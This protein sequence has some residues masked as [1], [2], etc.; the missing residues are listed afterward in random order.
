MADSD[1]SQ[2]LTQEE[3]TALQSWSTVG[4]PSAT[5]TTPYVPD[6]E[7]KS[8]FQPI[9]SPRT[10]AVD[11]HFNL[12]AYEKFTLGHHAREME[13]KW[14]IYCEDN[15]VHFHRSW[16]GN[17]LF[18]FT[19]VK[20]PEMHIGPNKEL[21]DYKYYKVSS[22][23]VEQDPEVYKATDEQ[24]IK[25]TILQVM[26]VLL[27]VQL[28]EIAEKQPPAT[29]NE[30][31]PERTANPTEIADEV[32]DFLDYMNAIKD[33]STGAKH[34][35]KKFVLD[36]A[37]APAKEVTDGLA[38]Y[39]FEGG[40]SSAYRQPLLGA[41]QMHPKPACYIVVRTH[42]QNPD[43]EKAPYLQPF[44]VEVP[45]DSELSATVDDNYERR[46]EPITKG[47]YSGLD[48]KMVNE[49][50]NSTIIDALAPRSK[51]ERSFWLPT[52]KFT[53]PS[54]V[55]FA[56]LRE[57]NRPEGWQDTKDRTPMIWF[58]KDFKSGALVGSAYSLVATLYPNFKG[59]D[60]KPMK[61]FVEKPKAFETWRKNMD[62]AASAYFNDEKIDKEVARALFVS[63]PSLIPPEYQK[64]VIEYFDDF[65]KFLRSHFLDTEQPG[66]DNKPST[67][68]KES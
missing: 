49:Q 8:K 45:H 17:E 68:P 3:T 13:D 34:L 51:Y 24:E 41:S 55:M 19:L 10:I 66:S 9:K 4:S 43:N 60:L 27:G 28:A 58:A 38:Y 16:T 23:E 52:K 21:M 35:T 40:P 32:A 67:D 12:N 31:L 37:Q 22:F 56:Y 59:E 1:Q 33:I 39:I 65:W 7:Q 47:H 42:S 6:D 11:W 44:W 25:N 57:D 15:V 14:N 26:R 30:A 63:L 62:S 54:V 61:T 46:L 2:E 29:S 64:W 36:E 18:R 5:P 53:T 48:H 50:F 20:T